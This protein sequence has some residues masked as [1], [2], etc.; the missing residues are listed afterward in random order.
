MKAVIYAR[1]SSDN[2]REESIEGQIRECKEFAE[3]NDITILG[4]YID[5]ALSAKT[6]NRPEFQKMIEDSA[7]QLF[8]TVIVWKLDRFSRNRYDS[9]HNKAIL[10][11]NGVKVIS[12][13]ENIA[14]DSTGILLESMLEGYAEYYSA[15]LSEKVIRGR[16]ENALK[17]KHIGGTLPLGLTLDSEQRFQIDPLTAPLV[18]EIFTQYKEGK[19]IKQ[20]VDFLNEKNVQTKKGGPM[21]IN[22]VARILHNRRY[23]GEYRYRDIFHPDG[24]PA[25]ISAELFEQVQNRL[26]KNKKAP[27]RHKAKEEQYLLTTKL[28]CGRCGAFMVGESGTSHTKKIHQYYKCVTAKKHKACKK[29]AIKKD[30]IE[31]V[32]INKTMALLAD[33]NV[34]QKIVNTV[35]E[36]QKRENVQLPILKK[37]LADTEKSIENLLNAIQQGILTT[38]TK[39]RLEKLE[40]TKDQLEISIAK[41][42]LQKPKVTE[43][44]LIVWLHKFRG[45]DVNNLEHRQQLVDRF[46][47]AVYVYDD[48]ITFTYNYREGTEQITFEE[49]ESSDLGLLGAPQTL[50]S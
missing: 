40:D 13:K 21:T 31:A 17:C 15:E 20:I 5:R 1:Y 14:E 26:N 33:D 39:E 12:A 38:S 3:R 6:D 18:V 29:K 41:E 9:A 45:I 10:R 28:F 32:V 36:I 7:K 48:Y 42:E 47:N 46:V 4:S 34:I 11:K 35:M 24:I 30:Y 19:T 8:D 50:E 2:Q 22:I 16:T 25:I 43:D 27:A 44:N 23:I 37:Q 49:I